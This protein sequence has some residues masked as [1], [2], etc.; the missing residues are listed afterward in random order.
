MRILKK[1]L[2]VTE[3]LEGVKYWDRFTDASDD[4]Y[5]YN[6][7]LEKEILKINI[8]LVDFISEL[9]RELEVKGLEFNFK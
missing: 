4:S 9:L 6:E 3:S 7:K 1:R 8:V 2:S 5:N